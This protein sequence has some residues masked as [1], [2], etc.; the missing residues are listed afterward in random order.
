MIDLAFEVRGGPVPKGYAFA[1]WHE[2]VR[3]LPWLDAEERA[4]ILSLRG[5]ASAEGMLLAQRAKLVL[6]LPA[7]LAG[8]ALALSGQQLNIGSGVLSVG[9]STERPLQPH[10]TLHAHMVESAEEEVRF[11]AG[12]AEQLQKMQITCKWI[13]GKHLTVMGSGRSLSGYSLVLHDLKPDESLQVQRAGLGGSR[14]FGCGIF[15][16]YKAITGLD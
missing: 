14:H 5:A 11:L 2:V 8:Q 9:M 15:I 4:G 16:P 13:C 1:L 7:G 12:V 6:R 10:T 3:I